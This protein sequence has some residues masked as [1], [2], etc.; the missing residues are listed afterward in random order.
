VGPSPEDGVG[1]LSIYLAERLVTK[2]TRSGSPPYSRASYNCRE[3][4]GFGLLE[5]L[6]SG[7]T[8]GI[9]RVCPVLPT[10]DSRFTHFATSSIWSL[11]HCVSLAAMLAQESLGNGGNNN[12]HSDHQERS[13]YM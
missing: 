10:A 8:T 3:S 6:T 7:D 9:V 12:L 13:G 2:L 5:E 1:Y 4:P 11:I